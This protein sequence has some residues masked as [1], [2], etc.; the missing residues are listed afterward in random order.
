MHYCALLHREI[1]LFLHDSTN[2]YAMRQENEHYV[3]HNAVMMVAIPNGYPAST[4]TKECSPDQKKSPGGVL[5]DWLVHAHTCGLCVGKLSTH[6][7][8]PL[9]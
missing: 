9:E 6:S 1:T 5:T 8:C 3:Y 2:A 4:A 7:S